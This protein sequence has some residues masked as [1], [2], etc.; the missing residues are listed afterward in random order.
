MTEA[1][2]TELADRLGH[3]LYGVGF[4]NVRSKGSS[5]APPLAIDSTGRPFAYAIV[6]DVTTRCGTGRLSVY[7]VVDA[8]ELGTEEH[9]ERV[10]YTAEAAQD[11]RAR[12]WVAVPEGELPQARARLADLGVHAR[13]LQV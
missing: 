7:V 8:D 13:L 4:R 10:R 1:K 12:F 5:H 2:R 11:H 9:A 6:P 3:I